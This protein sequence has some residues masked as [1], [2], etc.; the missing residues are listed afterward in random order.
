MSIDLEVLIVS[1]CKKILYFIS[2][3]YDSDASCGVLRHHTSVPK[4]TVVCVLRVITRSTD[5]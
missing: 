2:S 1:H 3:S 4:S 5:Y